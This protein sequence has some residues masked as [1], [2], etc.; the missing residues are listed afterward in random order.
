MVDYL[1]RNVTRRERRTLAV[2]GNV[3]EWTVDAVEP[4]LSL[5]PLDW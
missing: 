3:L 1:E 5:L 2:C 4:A